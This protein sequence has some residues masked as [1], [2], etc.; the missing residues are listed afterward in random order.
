MKVAIVHDWITNPGG[1]E[2]VIQC[3]LEIFPDAPV[4]T[5]VYNRKR[6]AEYFPN[7]DIRTSFLDRLPF[8]ATKYPMYLGLMPRAFEQFDLRGYDVVLSSS[9]SC[10]KGVLT[11][12]NTLHV[13]Y[14]NTPMRYAW[15][16]YFD[17]L[18]H[19]SNPLRKFL[20][21]SLMYRI[22]MWD[23]LSSNRV[24]FFIANSHNVAARIEKHYRRESA[25]IYPP[26]SIPEVD[27][28]DCAPGGYYLA[29][30]RLVSYKRIDL[31][32]Q[33]FRSLNLPL[34]IAGEGPEYKALKKMAGPNIRFAGRVSEEQKGDLFRHCR[35]FVFPGEED[36]GIT[37]VEAQG[38]GKPVIAFGKGGAME[39]V[40]DGVTG[41]HFH[42]QTADSLADAVRRAEQTGFDPQKI[43]ENA[44]SFDRS[45]FK[46]KLLS[47][48]QEKQQSFQERKG[49]KW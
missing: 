38:Y 45:V 40:I 17:Y 5:A 26:V 31:A 1:A 35:G 42:E 28:Q 39:T 46:D 48:I 20:I 6:M 15:D 30:S 12:A 11:D 3:M 36:F 34:V 7:A 23:V 8:S 22:R 37:P 47:F 25:V 43:R 2:T 49:M 10:A 44:L 21:R 32:V 41:I 24:D 27:R 33:A 19:S 9:T 14:C 18:N 16:F 29:V 13:C 4:Y